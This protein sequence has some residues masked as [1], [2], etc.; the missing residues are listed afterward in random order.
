MYSMEM[1]S[2]ALFLSVHFGNSI[3]SARPD[4]LVDLLSKFYLVEIFLNHCH[5]LFDAEVSCHPTIVGF[6]D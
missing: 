4:I 2:H 6:L 5:C 3:G 1:D